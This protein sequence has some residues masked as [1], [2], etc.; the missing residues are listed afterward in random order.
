[1]ILHT[2]EY[3][4]LSYPSYI[5]KFGVQICLNTNQSK[6]VN[7]GFCIFIAFPNL[8][9]L[10]L[11]FNYD[12]NLHGIQEKAVNLLTLNSLQHAGGSAD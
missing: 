10:V 12:I 3:N 1:M 6:L 11:Y 9:S 8:I 4:S 5:T 2:R 7:P